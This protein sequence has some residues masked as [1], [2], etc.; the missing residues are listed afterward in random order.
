MY[1]CI[2]DA[3]ARSEDQGKCIL[4][5]EL[6]APV[7]QHPCVPRGKMPLWALKWLLNACSVLISDQLYRGMIGYTEAIGQ[8]SAVMGGVRGPRRVSSTV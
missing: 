4:L 5:N 2:G 8:L 7:T 6:L 1:D 3:R